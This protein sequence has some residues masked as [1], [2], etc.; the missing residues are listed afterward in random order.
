[1]H[2]R[3]QAAHKPFANPIRF[4]RSRRYLQFFDACTIYHC[5]KVRAILLIS[6][7]NQI[8]RSFSP[9]RCF[10]QL[11]CRPCIRREFCNARMH[12]P[13][14]FQFHD[15]LSKLH[16]YMPWLKQP[17]IDNRKVAC[18]D[19]TRLILQEGRPGPTRIW[20]LPLFWHVFLDA[21]FTHF[22]PQFQQFTTNSLR[23]P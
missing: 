7:A 1:M 17:V 15:L 9:R 20:R 5:R 4:R 11:L 14:H 16:K 8:L 19:V 6:I 22:Y 2:S 13:T 23:S 18:P 12:D 21:P 3:A 10:P